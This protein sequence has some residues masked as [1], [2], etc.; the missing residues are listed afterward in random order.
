MTT[1]SSP[2]REVVRLTGGVPA[3]TT[4]SSRPQR[5]NWITPPRSNAWVEGEYEPARPSSISTVFA[6]PRASSNAVA[7][8]AARA[9]TTMTSWD[10]LLDR[11]SL[12]HIGR[13]FFGAAASRGQARD[14][15]TVL[16]APSPA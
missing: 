11:S 9:P 1:V 10:A 3:A 5:D 6:P 8:P 13:P 2:Y 16:R 12:G 4:S 15:R 7:A 14:A